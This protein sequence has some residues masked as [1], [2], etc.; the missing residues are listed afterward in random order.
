MVR[1]RKGSLAGLARAKQSQSLPFPACLITTVTPSVSARHG[2]PRILSQPTPSRSDEVSAFAFSPPPA[3]VDSSEIS[4]DCRLTLLSVSLERHVPTTLCSG[5]QLSLDLVSI[6]ASILGEW[7]TKGKEAS[8]RGRRKAS[9]A[10]SSKGASSSRRCMVGS[11]EA[12]FSAF[13]K[14]R[15]AGVKEGRPRSPAASSLPSDLPC[16]SP[17]TRAGF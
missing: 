11:R 5:M 9:G 1:G 6:S 13:I 15:T 12:P 4:S 2:T 17:P 10:V 16:R 8:E 7:C 14:Y 3:V